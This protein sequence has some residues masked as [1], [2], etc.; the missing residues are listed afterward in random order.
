MKEKVRSLSGLI[1]IYLMSLI[2]FATLSVIINSSALT[3]W[4]IY[5]Y[6]L[7]PNPGTLAFWAILAGAALL[8]YVLLEAACK[9]ASEAESFINRSH[10]ER[11]IREKG[12]VVIQP[13]FNKD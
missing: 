6:Y 8:L 3:A 11:D 7:A 5:F 4:L 1:E 10:L 2:S 13:L 12:M 9:A